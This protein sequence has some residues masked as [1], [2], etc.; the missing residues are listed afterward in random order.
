LKTFLVLNGPAGSG[1]GTLAM[2][3][4]KHGFQIIGAG[5]ELRN[6]IKN[7]AKDDPL[8]IRIERKVNLGLNADT[9]D[10]Y[11]IIEKKIHSLT[12]RIIGDGI[13]RTQDQAQWLV[14]YVNTQQQKVHFINLV[15][16]V[17][18]LVERLSNRFF[19]PDSPHPYPSYG[20]AYIDCKNGQIPIVRKDDKPEAIKNRLNEYQQNID[21][22][23][24]TL[25]NQTHIMVHDIMTH[26]TPEKVQDAVL[27]AIK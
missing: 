8:R 1:K 23:M 2:N 17:E 25:I 5:E 14:N 3:L 15:C 16:P 27:E 10:L 20:A 24:Q 7:A 9:K 26:D 6:Y 18:I 13:I 11:S 21:K 12:G 19:I 4:Q 22:I